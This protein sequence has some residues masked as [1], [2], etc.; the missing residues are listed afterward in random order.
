MT[1]SHPPLKLYYLPKK[2]CKYT[3]WIV[4]PCLPGGRYSSHGGISLNVGYQV[5][6]IL[7]PLLLSPVCC[8]ILLLTSRFLPPPDEE[9]EVKQEVEKLEKE[10]EQEEG[11]KWRERGEGE[12]LMS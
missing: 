10:E 6:I 2:C 5:A 7:T 11:G 9:Q 1:R 8:L 4:H 12:K 3:G